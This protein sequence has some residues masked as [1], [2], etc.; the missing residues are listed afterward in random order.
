MLQSLCR[1]V[2]RSTLLA[3]HAK[4]P[5]RFLPVCVQG[6]LR[7]QYI[8]RSL[9]CQK[10]SEARQIGAVRLQQNA[11]HLV[12]MDRS[13]SRRCQAVDTDRRQ[14]YMSVGERPPSPGGESE[15]NHQ[16]TR[17]RR[18]GA[19]HG[20][21]RLPRAVKRW[22]SSFHQSNVAISTSLAQYASSKLGRS[23]ERSVLICTRSPTDI[24][25]NL[26]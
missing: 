18:S 2:A 11:V 7:E 19:R 4:G 12:V 21:P 22:K 15:T 1:L 8:Q 17:R 14:P 6:K 23:N 20:S 13:Q 26:S 16:K 24:E 3:G 10:V 9:Q 5:V 25:D